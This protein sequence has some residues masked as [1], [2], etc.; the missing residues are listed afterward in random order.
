MKFLLASLLVSSA[1][2]AAPA[3]LGLYPLSLPL[4]QEQLG[5]R[6]GAQ[7]REGAASL[8]G[9]KS[10]DLL[11]H[12]SCGAD[13]PPCL[14]EAARRAGLEA[15]I[16]AQVIAFDNG[17][18]WMLREVAGDG[19][20][21]AEKGGDIR[22]GPLDLEGALER[23]VC[24]MV[25]AAPCEG[26]LRVAPGEAALSDR[27]SGLR[28]RVDGADRGPLPA[29]V[30]VPVGRHAVKLDEAERRVRISYSSTV[31]LTPVLRDGGLALLDEA[32]AQAAPVAAVSATGAPASAE[33]RARASRVLLLSGV[34]LLAAAGGIAL[35]NGS[36]SGPN[37]RN[38][39]YAATAL[40]ATGAGAV[41]A[42]GLLFVLTPGG[43]GLRGEF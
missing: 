2:L 20:L 39:G 38:A 36:S 10:F 5:E 32:E 27:V 33:P 29:T 14:A 43:A 11:P 19:K 17:Y 8:P 34:G 4:G 37:S 25:G 3:R 1:A 6:L 40:A 21:L 31:R 30:R 42:G 24:E 16:S 22:G 18:R 23:G 12:S 9:V 26:E 35:Y 7:L 41:V 15:V 28:L 13:E